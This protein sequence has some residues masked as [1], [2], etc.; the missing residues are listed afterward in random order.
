VEFVIAK[1]DFDEE[2]HPA[3][4]GLLQNPVTSLF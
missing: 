3:R 4:I 2:S 1:M